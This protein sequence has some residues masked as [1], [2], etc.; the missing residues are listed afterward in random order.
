[1]SPAYPSWFLPSLSI[2]EDIRTLL[3]V[4]FGLL[5]VQTVRR[6]GLRV[7]LR[8]AI[9][10]AGASVSAAVGTLFSRFNFGGTALQAAFTAN[11]LSLTIHILAIG[12]SLYSVW[13]LWRTLHDIARKSASADSVAQS[14]D[15]PDLW[16]PPPTRPV[17]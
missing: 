2:F 3:M 16:P 15:S 10:A 1:M 6:P 5:I 9:P 17:R 7:H 11:T 4:V 8:W 12:L 13:I 14:P